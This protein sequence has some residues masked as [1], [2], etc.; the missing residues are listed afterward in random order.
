[1]TTTITTELARYRERGRELLAACAA[2]EADGSLFGDINTLATLYSRLN[3]VLGA[4][5]D[6]LDASDA[7]S[8]R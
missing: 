8:T 2:A 4:M 6:E 1:M 7:R 3:Y 5:L